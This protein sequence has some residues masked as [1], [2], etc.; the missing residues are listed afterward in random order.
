L[1]QQDQTARFEVHGAYGTSPSTA[2]PATDAQ[3]P[4][5]QAEVRQQS[6]DSIQMKPALANQWVVLKQAGLLADLPTE[7]RPFESGRI[8]THMKSVRQFNFT[9]PREAG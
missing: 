3:A 4:T 9:V 5:N 7:A 8:E 2:S 1:I 6:G